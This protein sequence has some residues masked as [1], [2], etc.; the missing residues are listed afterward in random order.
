MTKHFS[1]II[2]LAFLLTAAGFTRY[3]AR[4][5]E[6]EQV[7]ARESFAGFP[8]HLGPWRRVE[9]QILDPEIL[10]KL[11]PDDYL[12]HT[13]ANEKGMA[14]FLFIG[15][16]ASQRSGKTYHSPQNCLPG[17]GW[18]MLRH[19]RYR[20][21]EGGTAQGEINLYLIGK[22]GEKM[23]TFYW[24]QGRGRIVAS[25]YWGKLYTV[26]DAVSKRR[27]DGALVRV[28]VPVNERAGGEPKALE[29][30]LTFVQLLLP[31]LTRY[32]PN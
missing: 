4:A 18:A 32:I 19:Q 30:G 6:R 28:I 10:E 14:A 26:M 17:A 8:E 1:F 22:G 15:Y 24:Y 31:Q 5:S 3:L 23:L 20:L 2:M 9:S 29:E 12:S 11:Q 27:S 7:P 13:Y 21:G 16:Y 25:E